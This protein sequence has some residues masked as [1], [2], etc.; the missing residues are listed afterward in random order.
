MIGRR[1]RAARCPAR[2]TRRPIGELA[3]A[4]LSVSAAASYGMSRPA[5]IVAV[6]RHE[7]ARLMQA[8]Y[9]ASRSCRKLMSPV[10]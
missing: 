1:R 3:G 6:L 10:K 2:D 8:A 4:A 5:D 7:Q 9:R